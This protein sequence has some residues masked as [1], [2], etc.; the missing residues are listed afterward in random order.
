M[1]A[2]RGAGSLLLWGRHPASAYPPPDLPAS[3]PGI[4]GKRAHRGG[5]PVCRKGWLL[6]EGVEPQTLHFCQSSSEGG[7]GEVT[8]AWPAWLLR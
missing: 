7:R 1:Q 5:L 8:R 2:G 3:G 4:L 6:C